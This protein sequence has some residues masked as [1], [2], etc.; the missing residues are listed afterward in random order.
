MKITL[1][2]C[3]YD[4]KTVL[5][6]SNILCRLHTNIL[7]DFLLNAFGGINQNRTS[8]LLGQ[9]FSLKATEQWHLC[10]SP[11]EVY[12]SDWAGICACPCIVMIPLIKMNITERYHF[13]ITII[14]IPAVV[15][16]RKGS[17]AGQL[18]FLIMQYI[19]LRYNNIK[20]SILYD[21]VYNMEY[22]GCSQ[23]HMPY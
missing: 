14:D 5:K 17:I 6:M 20:L 21:T 2:L 13:S 23:T 15:K 4:I 1:K 10:I 19:H 22:S 11:E 7:N 18:L 3:I 8:T 16:S 9:D 12:A